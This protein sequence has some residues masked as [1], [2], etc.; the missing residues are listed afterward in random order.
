[1]KVFPLLLQVMFCRDTYG[2]P[3]LHDLVLKGERII[4]PSSMRKKMKDLLH[5]GHVGIK[6][7]KCRACKSIYWPGLN[8][9]L[10]DFVLNCSACLKY[11]NDQPKEPLI[12]HNI[13]TEVWPKVVTDFNQEHTPLALAP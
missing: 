7:C 8:G 12:P 6:R 2:P 13:S 3:Y 4:V 11:R 9:E 10:K 1:M 5:T